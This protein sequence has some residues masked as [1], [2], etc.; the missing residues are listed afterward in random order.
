MININSHIGMTELL[1]FPDY[2]GEIKGAIKGR[3]EIRRTALHTCRKKH[4][5]SL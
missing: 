5:Q 1:I 2:L 3:D 4:L